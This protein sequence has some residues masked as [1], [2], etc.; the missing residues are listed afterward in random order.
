MGGGNDFCRFYTSLFI[1]LSRVSNVT[2]ICYLLFYFGAFTV[3]L[4]MQLHLG[5]EK[6]AN[7]GNLTLMVDWN[8]FAYHKGGLTSKTRLEKSIGKGIRGLS[9]S[10]FV[11]AVAVTLLGAAWGRVNLFNPQGWVELAF[12]AGVLVFCYSMFLLRDRNWFD[13]NAESRSLT[14]TVNLSQATVSEVMVEVDDILA[15]DLFGTIDHIYHKAPDNFMVHMAES[16]FTSSTCAQFWA[17]LGVEPASWQKL[18]VA[19]LGNPVNFDQ[20]YLWLFAKLTEVGIYLESDKLGFEC[21]FFALTEHYTQGMLDMGVQGAELQALKMW[22]RNQQRKLSYYKKWQKMSVL[23]PKGVVNRAYTS[24]YAPTLEEYA[25]D[26]TASAANGNFELTIGR[27]QVMSSVIKVL[28]KEQNTACLLVG[29]PGVGKGQLLKHL[30][31]RMVVEDVPSLLQDKRLVAFNFQKAFTENM[32]LENFKKVLQSLLSEV[33]KARN[34][35]LVLDDIDQMFN[36]RADLQAEVVT[37]LVNGIAKQNLK[38]VATAG[39]DGYHR[40]IKTIRPLAGLFEVVNMVEPEPLIALQILIDEAAK[41]ERE[42]GIKVQVDAL[43]QIVQLAPQY[44]YERVMPDKAIDLLEE[45]ILEMRDRGL[46]FLSADVVGRV[47]SRKVGVNVG[48]ISQSESVKLQKL[49]ENMHKRVVGQSVAITAIASALRRS[50]AGLTQ[51]KKPISSFL[52]FGPT[53]VGKTEVA[54]T[55]AETYYGDEKMMVRIDMSEYQ[56]EQNLQRLIGY[57]DGTKFVGGYLTEA[58][59]AR[60]FTLI[61]L[62][63]L[64]KANPKVLDLFLQVLDEGQLTD[65]AGRKID[66]TNTIIIATSNAGSREIAEQIGEGMKYDAVYHQVYERLREVFRVEFLNRFDKIIMFKPL[67]PA[68]VMEIAVRMLA[69]LGDNLLEK[70]IM[71]KYSRQL[72]DDLLKEGY[73]PIYGARQMRRVIQEE[74]EDVIADKIVAGELVSGKTIT[75][76]S[77]AKYEIV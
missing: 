74:V 36:I 31:V 9:A 52:F 14:K 59:K 46:K 37:L 1:N 29:D 70:G 25:L 17:R 72:V 13:I 3:N 21:L 53:G 26:L 18:R 34:I 58:V 11:F 68:E 40:F 57:V 75:F 30:A 63:E 56:E 45:S 39:T 19:V 33:G 20:N 22:V 73:D 61:L 67:L 4:N 8:D 27:E 35:V 10:F 15:T 41:K 55:L 38:V 32:T 28:Q 12:W 7:W 60:P 76:V 2:R 6:L 49:E 64:E 66:F 16:L 48:N 47:V 65:G 50:R 54:K 24:R 62:D 71:L 51:G 69:K 44:A 23:K 42:L 77:S 5:K 43:R